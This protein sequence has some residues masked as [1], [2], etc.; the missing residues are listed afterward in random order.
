MSLVI[1]SECLSC[2]ICVDECPEEAIVEGSIHYQI[3]A[4]ACSDC[5]LCM[6]L[7]PVKAVLHI[8]D[9]DD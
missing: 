7:C 8:S 2:A 3:L 9:D 6:R 4:E 1:N 5:G